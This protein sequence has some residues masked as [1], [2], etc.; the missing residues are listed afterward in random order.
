MPRWSSVGQR[1]RGPAGLTGVHSPAMTQ[2]LDEESLRALVE[3]CADPIAVIAGD[4]R[5]TYVSPAV[6]ACLGYA[7]EDV[8]GTSA[9]SHVH[10][11]DAPRAHQVSGGGGGGRGADCPGVPRAQAGRGVAVAG[12]DRGE[13]PR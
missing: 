7:P 10:P 8:I 13:S 6:E 9:F 11:D 4:G 2:R 3:Y 5:I 1:S 12:G